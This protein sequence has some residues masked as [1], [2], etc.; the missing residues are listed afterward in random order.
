MHMHATSRLLQL[1][2]GC[3]HVKSRSD[4]RII[5][6]YLGHDILNPIPTPT[7]SPSPL[8]PHPQPAS[9]GSAAHLDLLVDPLVAC[10]RWV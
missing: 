2:T 8:P 5:K 1:V 10:V 7:P 4:G 6:Q 3:L 9:P